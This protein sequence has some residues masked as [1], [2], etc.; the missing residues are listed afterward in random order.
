MPWA[1]D[2]PLV[3][4]GSMCRRHLHGEHGILHVLDVLD[5]AFS[6]S[7]ARFHLFGL[8]S[9]AIAIVSQ[10]PR[11]ASADSQAYGIAAR[12][13]ARKAGVPKSDAMLAGVMAGWY[14]KQLQDV[15]ARPPGPLV[16]VW[17]SSPAVSITEIESRVAA[18]AEELRALHEAGEIDWSGLSP[19]AAYEFA[20]LN[21]C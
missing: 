14:K 21:D 13:N 12:Q 9:Q 4:I 11:V 6:G 16:Q 2:F 19:Q 20:F 7:N 8:K 5:R 1:R 3:G 17:P 18:A 15:A 10:Y